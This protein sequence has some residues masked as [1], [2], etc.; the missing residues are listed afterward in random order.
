MEKLIKTI[1][2]SGCTIYAINHNQRREVGT[3][4][5][6]VE[7]YET[8]TS[9]PIM[10]TGI[11]KKAYHFSVIFCDDVEEKD[12]DMDGIM[13]FDL[14]MRLERRDGIYAPYCLCGI[15]DADISPHRWTFTVSDLEAVDRMME[16]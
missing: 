13:G 11:R 12:I 4:V 2:G 7:I 5:P 10:G 3:A 6:T 14:D 8:E 1:L 9:V 16:F 15:T